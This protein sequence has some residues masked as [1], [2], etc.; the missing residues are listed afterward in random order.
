[1]HRNETVGTLD[2]NY[3]SRRHNGVM[4]PMAFDTT[5]VTSAANPWRK[6][7]ASDCQDGPRYKALGNS[8][9]VPVVRWIGERIDAVTSINTAQAAM[10]TVAETEVV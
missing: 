10:N 3:G 2:A 4:L 5:Q 6:K 9:A 7:P 1:M 8:W